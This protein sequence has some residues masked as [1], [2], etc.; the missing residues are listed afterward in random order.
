MQTSD[1]DD[2]NG[3]DLTVTPDVELRASNPPNEA[4]RTSELVK[5]RQLAQFRQQSRRILGNNS[6]LDRS[7]PVKSMENERR[8]DYLLDLL[9]YQ[10]RKEKIYSATIGIWLLFIVLG[11]MATV[12]EKQISTVGMYS[13]WAVLLSSSILLVVAIKLYDTSR[14]NSIIR[15]YEGIATVQELE[16]CD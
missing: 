11:L 8:N 5:M 7:I 10:A 13:V 14:M 12:L 9:D 3:G 2:K 15:K 1:S 6:K 16:A 4:T